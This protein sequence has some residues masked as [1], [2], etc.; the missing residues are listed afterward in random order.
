VI[1]PSAFLVPLRKLQPFLAPE[2]LHLLVVSEAPGCSRHQGRR[3]W[4]NPRR[5]GQVDAPGAD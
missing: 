1:E 3:R 4:S 5:V 2:T